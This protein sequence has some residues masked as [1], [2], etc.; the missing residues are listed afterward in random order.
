MADDALGPLD[1]TPKPP[2]ENDNSP[3]FRPFIALDLLRFDGD[4]MVN[5]ERVVRGPTVFTDSR[6]MEYLEMYTHVDGDP[7]AYQRVVMHGGAIIEMD[8]RTETGDTT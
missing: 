7:L 1:R 2:D 6:G 4:I 5:G 8:D 3:G